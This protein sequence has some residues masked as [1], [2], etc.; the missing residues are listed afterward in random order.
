MSPGATEPLRADRP[1]PSGPAEPGDDVF[2]KRRADAPDGFFAVEA[3]GLRWLAAVPGGVRVVQPVDVRP[4]RLVL[5]RLP[6]VAPTAAAADELGRRLAVTHAAGA[7][8][9]GAGPDGWAGDGYVGPL[10]LP[11][12]A[13]SSWGPWFAEHRLLPYLRLAHDVGALD[14]GGSATVSRLLDRLVAEP[15]LAGPSAERPARLHGDLWN[16]NVLWTAD[17]VVLVDPAAHGGH[18]E[19]DLA[20][21]ALFGLPHLSRVLGA[22]DDAAPL[23]EGWRDRVALHQL[24]PLLVHAALFG[25][26]YG[27]RAV[28]AA[29]RYVRGR[30]GA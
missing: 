23:A 30:P 18:R 17:G 10:P 16:G 6:E 29:A 9:W 20:M 12:R 28:E 2:V 8:S 22:Y 7:P 5:P 26:G 15:D 3:A 21:L 24:H 27:A 1:V 14:A 25:G 19:T 4:D 11:H 13:G